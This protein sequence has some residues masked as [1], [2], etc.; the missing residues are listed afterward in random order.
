MYISFSMLCMKSL[1]VAPFEHL[2]ECYMYGCLSDVVVCKC[3]VLLFFLL[4]VFVSWRFC[5][6]FLFGSTV[7]IECLCLLRLTPPHHMHPYA[8]SHTR[9]TLPVP[10]YKIALPLP[11]YRRTQRVPPIP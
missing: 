6:G 5:I 4:M 8:K 3:S 10:S 9:I 1:Y 7:T 11:S 2:T